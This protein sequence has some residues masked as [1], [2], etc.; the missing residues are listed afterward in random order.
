MVEKEFQLG[1]TSQTSVKSCIFFRASR[2]SRCTSSVRQKLHKLEKTFLLIVQNEAGGHESCFEVEIQSFTPT[3]GSLSVTIRT[4]LV[5]FGFTRGLGAL[6]SKFEKKTHPK[7]LSSKNTWWWWLWWCVIKIFVGVQDLGAPPNPS[8]HRTLPLRRTGQNVL[9]SQDPPKIPRK[10]SQK[11]KNCGGK[12]ERN[13]RPPPLGSHTWGP[14]FSK[15]W[16]SPPFEPPP[17]GTLRGPL[18]H[19]RKRPKSCLGQKWYLPFRLRISVWG[20]ILG[21]AEPKRPEMSHGFRF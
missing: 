6:S 8:L 9:E 7:T 20:L 10:D 11:R 3:P 2:L 12:K 19:C 4:S 1:R 5:Y 15:V 14:A 17:F 18:F 13:F 16:T 21:E